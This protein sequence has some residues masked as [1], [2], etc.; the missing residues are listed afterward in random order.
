MP[1]FQRRGPTLRYQQQHLVWERQVSS[2]N[3]IREVI[4]GAVVLVLVGLGL[5]GWAVV[6]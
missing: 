1:N 4:G 3:I 5:V 6:L 2:I